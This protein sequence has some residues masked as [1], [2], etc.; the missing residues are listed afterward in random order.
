MNL[1]LTRISRISQRHALFHSR[2]SAYCR[3]FIPNGKHERASALR[4]ITLICYIPFKGLVFAFLTS[5]PSGV[6][7]KVREIRVK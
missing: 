6:D 3:V 2:V 1:F 7:L 5:A 4:V